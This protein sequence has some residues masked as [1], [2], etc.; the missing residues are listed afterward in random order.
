[1]YH[2]QIRV[3][4]NQSHK[5]GEE[6]EERTGPARKLNLNYEEQLIQEDSNGWFTS[7]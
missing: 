6:H 1:M 3:D 4:P 5:G 7:A 2:M